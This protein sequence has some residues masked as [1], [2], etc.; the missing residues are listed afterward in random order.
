MGR[1]N[2]NKL[3]IVRTLVLMDS[4]EE[5][6][7]VVPDLVSADSASG[8]T[9]KGAES[10]PGGQKIPVTIITGFLGKENTIL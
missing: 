3:F 5:D 10:E 9:T 7:E 1:G 6:D 2:V 8:T 4:E